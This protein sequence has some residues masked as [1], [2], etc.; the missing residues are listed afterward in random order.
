[1]GVGK[2]LLEVAM[3]QTIQASKIAGLKALVV[4]AINSK[5]Y[6]KY[7]AKGFSPLSERECKAYLPIEYLI[8]QY[9]E[10]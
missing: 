8:K 10:A 4:D 2:L 1:L 3:K 6:Q 5:V 9:S 7:I